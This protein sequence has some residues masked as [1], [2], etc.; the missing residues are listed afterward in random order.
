MLLGCDRAWSGLSHHNIFFSE[1]YPQEFDDIFSD[2][3]L[4]DDPTIYVAN[5]SVSNPDDA[6]EGGS[7]LFILV[8]A[9]YVKGQNW[10][11]LK[12]TYSRYII[13][14][15]EKR[16]LDRLSESI[17]FKKILT[18]ADFLKNY[19]S[20]RGSIYGTSSNGLFSAF[21]RPR[22]KLRELEN[23]YLVGG[24]THPGGGIPLVIQSAFHADELMQ[25]SGKPVINRPA[26]PG[27]PEG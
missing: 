13:G 10:T 19:G 21:V 11:K 4:P 17:R 20:N 26:V 8:N 3:K 18:P 12:N 2:H 5:T 24:S 6:P 1:N 9:P 23:L 14:E 15:L 16:G 22:N 25:R 7:N 27:D